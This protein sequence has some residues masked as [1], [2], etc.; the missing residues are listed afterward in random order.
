MSFGRRGTF[1]GWG[2]GCQGAG[3]EVGE[4][5]SLGAVGPYYKSMQCLGGLGRLRKWNKKMEAAP[6][7]NRCKDTATGLY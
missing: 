6:G 7:F 4:G 3:Y 5:S 2:F 1:R